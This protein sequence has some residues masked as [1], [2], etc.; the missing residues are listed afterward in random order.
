MLM[1]RPAR[2][3]SIRLSLDPFRPESPGDVETLVLP[4]EEAKVT[5]SRSIQEVFDFLADGVNAPRWMS[6]VIESTPVGYSGGAGATYSQRTVSSLLGRK[7][8]VYRIVH[9]HSPMTLGVEASSLPG[10]PTAR[11][12][13]TP[14]DVGIT[15]L[16]VR[17]EF[18]DGGGATASMSAGQRWAT[19]VV[20]SLPQIK[21]ALESDHQ[22]EA[23]L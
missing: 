22:R 21:S 16:S 20:E 18:A 15:M 4:Y 14:M 3:R 8:I 7:W 10:R 6:W 11:F 2:T 12:R 13:L 5:V 23:A 19:H 9:H 1:H 17:A